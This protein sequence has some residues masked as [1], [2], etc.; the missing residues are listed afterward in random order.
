MAILNDADTNQMIEN[1][2]R[3]IDLT[4]RILRIESL[5]LAWMSEAT[6]L[7]SESHND[8]TAAV[9]AMRQDLI[10]K[11]AAAVAI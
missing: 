4:A 10:S 3:K 7:H 2:D 5:T 8:D 6:E 1:R 11:L 9:L